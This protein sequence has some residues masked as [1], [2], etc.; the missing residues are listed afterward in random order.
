MPRIILTPSL[1]MLALTFVISVNGQEAARPDRGVMPNGSYSLSDIENINVLNGNVN[2]RIP[3]AS[4]PPIAGGKLSWTVSAQYNSK[5]WNTTREQRNDDQLSWQPYMVDSPGVDGGWSLGST[6]V[7][8]FRNVSDDIQ[9]LWYPG[10]SGLPQWELDLINNYQWWKV[11]LRMPDGSEHEFRPL[12]NTSYSGSQGFLKGFFNVLPNGTAKRYYSVDGTFMFA[13]ISATN[14]WTVYMRDGTQIIQTPDGIQR[15]Q[16]TNGNKIKIFSD[17]SG[18]H[19]R[20]EQTNREIRLTYN[21]SGGGQYQVWYKTVTGLD[22]HIDVNLGTT[23]VQGKLYTVRAPACDPGLTGEVSTEIEIF[24]EIVFP[25]TEPLQP[26]RKFTF[27]YNSDTSSNQTDIAAFSCP[28]PGQNYTRAVSNGLGE[29]SRIVTPAGAIV[30]YSY[31][32]DGVSTFEPLGIDDHFSKDKITQKKI[33][34]DGGTIDTWTYD[35]ADS[36]ASGIVTAP[37]G[38]ISAES[39]YCSLPGSPGCPSDRAGLPYGSNRPFT[40]T[41]RHYINLIFSGADTNSPNGPMPFNS[42]VD[43]EYTTLRDAQGN[44]LK[45][46]A[47]TFTF[48]YNGNV[49]QEIHYDWFDPALVSR[50]AAGVPTGVPA[51]A[52]VLKVI[53]HSHY[54]QAP[55]A[56]STNVYAKR[57]IPG[58]TPLILNAPRETIK[59]SGKVQFSYDGQAYDVAPTV[60]N[61]TTKKVWLDTESRWITTS[62]TY[63]LYGNVTNATD[64]RGKVTQYFYDDAT[65]ALPNRVVVDPQNGTGTQTLTTV[66]DF[67]TGLIT[68]Q[69]DVNGQTSEIDYTNQLTANIDPFGRPGVTKSPPINIGGSN[70]KRRVTTTYLDSARQVIVATDLNAENDKLLKT[71]T[72]ID[73]LG[74]PVLTESTEDGTNYTISVRNAYLNMGQVTLTSSSMRSAAATT[75]SWTRVTKDIGGRVIEAATFSGAT[76]PAWTGTTGTF[77][78]AVT[79]AYN[80]NFTTVTDQAGKVRRS[81]VDAVG[82]LI[83]VDEPDGSGNLGTTA[84][85]VQPTSYVYDV[86]D[87]LTNVTQGTQTRMFTYDSLSRLRSAQNPESG[88]VNYQYDDNGNLLVKW[89]A[90]TDD[91]NDPT[92]RVSTHFEYDALNRVTRRWYNYSNLVTAGTHNTPALPAFVGATDEVKFY[93]DSQ[94]LSGAPAG[95]NRGSATGRLVAQLYG[96]GTNG[97]YYTYDVLGRQTVK[98]Q[99]VGSKNY[100]LTANYTLSG[101]LASLTYPSNHTITN[102]YDPAGRLT[103]FS[104]D[105]G[106]GLPR[107]YSTGIVYSPPGGLLKEQFGTN[108]AVYHKLHYNSRSQICDVRASNVNDEW[109]GELGALAFYYYTPVS[110]CGDGSNNNGNM[111]M[112]QTIINSV[113]FEDNYTYDSLNRLTAVSENQNGTPIGTQEYDYDRWGNRTIKTTTSAIFNKKQFSVNTANNRLGVPSGQSGVMDYDAAGNLT[114]DTYTGAGNRTY[115]AENKMTSAW[116][117]NNQAQTYK[118]DG[119]GQRIKRTVNGEETWQVYGFGGELIAEYPVNGDAT[120]PSKEYGY[121]NGELLVTSAL[122]TVWSDDA[123]PAGAAIAG[124]GDSWNWV[125]SAPGPFSGS[126]AHQSNIVAGLH[127]HYFY[128]ATATLTVN[129][130]EKLV[131]YVYLDPNNMPS[132]IMLQWNDGSWE[133]RAYWG[134]N[135]LPWGVDGTNSR[136]NMG[137]LPAAGSWVRLE[138]PANLVGLEGHTVHGMAFSMWGGR[139]TWDRAGKTSST[140]TSP[141]ETVWSQDAVPAG[142]AIAGDGD[143]WNWVSSN[144]GPFSGSAAHQSNIVAGL[145][146]H[147]FYGAT[148]TLSVNAGDKLVAYVYLDPSN[149]PSQ[150]MLQWAE[151]SSWEHRAYWGANNLP[152][153]VD[154]TNSRRY[155]GPLPA[156]G[157]WARLEVPASLVGLEGLT[158]HGMA[159][160]MWGGRATWDR[161][162]KVSSA[163]VGSAPQWLV[164]DQLGTPRMIIDQ[165]GTLANVKR[166]DYLPFGEELFAPVGGRSP[167]LGYSGG[168]AVRQ[169]FTQ[170]E[171]DIE[172][173]LDYFE[174]RYYASVQGRFTR[175]DPYNIILEA[176]ATAEMNE[177]KARAMFVNYLLHPQNWN[178]YAYVMN[179]PLKYID[180]TGEDLWLTGTEEQRA[181]EVQRIKDLVG[182]DAAKYLRFSEIC[183]EQGIVT[184]V[185]YT[186][187]AFTK[188]EPGVTVRIADIIDSNDVLEYRIATA[189]RDK[190]GAHTTEYY[191]GAATV[192]KEES[193][194]G[195]TQIFVHPNA[196]AITQ[197]IAGG[198]SIL[199]LSKSNDGKPLDFFDDIDDFHEFGHAYANI[200]DK[201]RVNSDESN[202]R[203]LDFENV[204]RQRRG[205][206]NRRVVH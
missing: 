136:R 117:G 64:A 22:Q 75:D 166:H 51:S 122:D 124:D 54:N 32:H 34:H 87:N 125:S 93:Y 15:I 106:D 163:G 91:P 157:S 102:T 24:R 12:D 131:A 41:E 58:A 118:Y 188:Y 201:V 110:H 10:N 44:N 127:Q 5:I 95:Y 144:P 13:R 17:G 160:S 9:R 62:N 52:T 150:I 90:R 187:N 165:T 84:T 27:S 169:Q 161:A 16:D 83:R 137:A 133:H 134:A 66:L 199:G 82:R 164:S 33:T 176:Q 178:R 123:V 105:L 148:A 72:T 172:T 114:N 99:Q 147:Y 113:Y 25:Q 11:V 76:Q 60:G 69:T 126:A 152:W 145:H 61:L 36:G 19:Y 57:S 197:S 7:F 139:A 20:D 149:M 153:G 42:V 193:L 116:G 167:A 108:T 182:A 142:A 175:P 128:G 198:A 179:N 154:G 177:D 31:T 194:N 38:S 28:G 59:G 85:P 141:I 155:M 185:E 186:S 29:L 1:L 158:L 173:G 111:V 40:R 115:D 190:S 89:D 50:D 138:V 73:M 21:P 191:G 174:A 202:K 107:I 101:A 206:P 46:S 77:T 68:S 205:L 2:I 200:I 65:H 71:R 119:A 184:V 170:K 94:A 132:Q 104:G 39:A 78:G 181:K 81:M 79:T 63:D 135:N 97:D 49:T 3:L 103:A 192:G 168:D 120:N 4:L 6:Y 80:A 30:D 55:A 86:F 26:Q 18:T 156:G 67:A 180:P 70:H 35:I 189:F 204:I 98:F 92:R 143:S 14:D 162:A 121:R 196:S 48:D 45:M 183:T 8:F 130:G 88:T 195:H 112:S 171:R 109:G 43:K 203:S 159:F 37:D 140:T 47:K 23:T 100:K 151:G 146:Q 96:T 74:R 129:S 56:S 53:T